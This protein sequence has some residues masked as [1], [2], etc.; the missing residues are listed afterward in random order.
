MQ[1]QLE[2]ALES[3]SQRW[4]DSR[5][6]VFDVHLETVGGIPQVHGEVLETFQLTELA[7]AL[8]EVDFSGVR[9]LRQLENPRLVV[10]TNLTSLHTG[11]SFLSEQLSQLLNGARVEVLKQEGS[12][13]YVRQADGYL[14]WT[15]LPYLGLVEPLRADSLVVAPVSPLLAQPDPESTRHTRVLGGTAVQV[16]WAQQ[17][18]AE[19]LLAGGLSGWLPLTDLRSVDHLPSSESQR[20]AQ[21]VADGERMT[22]VPYLWGG[23]SANGID[24]S[25]LAQLLHRW[26]GLTI[27]RDADMQCEAG[28][29]VEPPFQ[30]GDLLFFGEQGERRNITHVAVS[31][32][33]W[34][35]LHSSRSRNGV[36]QDNVQA[37]AGLRDSFLQAA[38]YLAE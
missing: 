30:P 19:V 29:P 21:M 35:I 13:A 9:A 15:Y 11:R 25:G 8:P 2:T 26:V 32:G 4:A 7:A 6:H 37:V 10:I 14:G 17:S 38:T 34:E 16:L 22:G 31:L 23:C 33:G 24:C 20:R 27:P 28:R 3:F 12:W 5:I 36:Y 1:N 18:W